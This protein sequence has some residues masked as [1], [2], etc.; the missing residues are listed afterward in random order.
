MAK[1]PKQQEAGIVS[2]AQAAKLLLVSEQWIRQLAKDGWFDA[3]GRGRYRLVEVVQGYIKFLRDENRRAS[4]SE[5]AKR[6]T[7][8]RAREIELRIE[9]KERS[10]IPFEDADMVIANLSGIV[11]GEMSSL[12]PRL[13]R[14]RKER[15]RFEKEVSDALNRIKQKAAD[16]SEA[17]RTGNIDTNP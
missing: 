17:L 16:A 5:A 7:D 10:L 11:L 1:Q 13:T 2:T 9:E 4:K 12:P 6:A 8:A 14:D 15:R 3:E